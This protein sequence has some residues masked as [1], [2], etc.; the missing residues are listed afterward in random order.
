VEAL[1][2]RVVCIAFEHFGEASDTDRSFASGGY[3]QGDVWV[4]PGAK[5]YEGLFK[6]KGLMDGFFGLMD[7]SKDALKTIKERNV[8]G[9]FKGD[10]MRM[11]GTFV[12]GPNGKPFLDHRQKYYG[13]NPEPAEILEAAKQA[14]EAFAAAEAAVAAAPTA[15]A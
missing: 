14:V 2:A 6:R 3:F 5:I 12:L 10:G 4:D 9:N 15:S 7:M 8:Q 1:G 11:G 13:D